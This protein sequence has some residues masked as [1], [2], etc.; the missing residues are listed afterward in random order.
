M[1]DGDDFL[2]PETAHRER[3]ATIVSAISPPI[4]LFI[5]A[6]SLRDNDEIITEHNKAYRAIKQ[7][8]SEIDGDLKGLASKAGTSFYVLA[9]VFYPVPEDGVVLL[10]GE[11]DVIANIVPIG[12]GY[13]L[14]GA[15]VER[16]SH[17]DMSDLETENFSPNDAKEYIIDGDKLQFERGTYVRIDLIDLVDGRPIVEIKPLKDSSVAFSDAL[18]AAHFRP[19]VSYFFE[20][21]G[22]PS[23]YLK[24]LR[25]QYLKSRRSLRSLNNLKVEVALSEMYSRQY[26]MIDDIAKL[27]TAYEQAAEAAR[28]NAFVSQVTGLIRLGFTAGEYVMKFNE[29]ELGKQK[30]KDHRALMQSKM[31]QISSSIGE[32]YG[33]VAQNN[34]KLSSMQSEIDALGREVQG[35]SSLLRDFKILDNLMEK[36]DQLHLQT[37]VRYDALGKPTAAGVFIGVLRN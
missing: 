22:L 33:E 23:E 31:G 5:A 2:D 18:R 12:Y 9:K 17:T 7:N 30:I 19:D 36:F 4:G 21:D 15:L 26:S 28:R 16:L 34:A 11:R 13:S 3:L 29:A 8:L 1:N 20:R 6:F 25:S 37:E 32:L 35:I 14:K 24:G 10:P 27:A